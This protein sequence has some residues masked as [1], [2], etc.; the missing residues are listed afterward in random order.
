MSTHSTGVR[1]DS[2]NRIGVFSVQLPMEM[3]AGM[4]KSEQVMTK[5]LI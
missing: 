1:D 4:E 2:G 3:K 5:V